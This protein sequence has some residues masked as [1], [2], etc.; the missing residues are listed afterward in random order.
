MRRKMRKPTASL[1]SALVVALALATAPAVHA[2]SAAFRA[3][4]QLE[5]TVQAT[6]TDPDACFVRTTSSQTVRLHTARA[7]RIGAYLV[8]RGS[9]RGLVELFPS[10]SGYALVRGTGTIERQ[11]AG[12]PPSQCATGPQ[13]DPP[14]CGRRSASTWAIRVEP[15]HA[16]RSGRH[17]F[18]G[19]SLVWDWFGRGFDPYSN[20]EPPPLPSKPIFHSGKLSARTLFGRRRKIVLHIGATTPY[21][22]RR[23]GITTEGTHTLTATLTLRRTP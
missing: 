15:Y 10:G 14:D 7:Q 2:K 5:E 22:Y 6:V 20:C 23:E 1:A 4:V 9:S 12:E 8:D 13:A 3:T 19:L 18:L 21:R 16:R 17:R 11:T